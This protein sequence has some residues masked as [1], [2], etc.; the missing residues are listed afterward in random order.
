M[1][2]NVKVM[3]FFTFLSSLLIF[4]SF[5]V[6]TGFSLS[7]CNCDCHCFSFWNDSLWLNFLEMFSDVHSRQNVY[8]KL[9][10][11][12][13]IYFLNIYELGLIYMFA[14]FRCTLNL[15]FLQIVL[16]VMLMSRKFS[17]CL[18][19]SNS[20]TYFIAGSCLFRISENLFALDLSWKRAWLSSTKRLNVLRAIW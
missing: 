17:E 19:S 15:Y 5:Y 4:G 9:C 7:W 10:F 16:L 3:S 1:H 2:L 20:T 18:W 11:F 14:S 6:P 12:L 13:D 8:W